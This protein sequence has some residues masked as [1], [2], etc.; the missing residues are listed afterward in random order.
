MDNPE[1]SRTVSPIIDFAAPERALSLFQQLW[2]SAPDAMAIVDQEGRIVLVNALLEQMF[3]Y[4][5]EELL[6]ASI[7]V[8]IPARVREK[9]RKHIDKYR[10]DPRVRAMGIGVELSA[11]RKDGSEFPAEISLAPLKTD[12]GMLIFSSIRDV[13]ERRRAEESRRET[14]AQLLAA[15]RIQEHLLPQAPPTIPGLDIAGASHPA[16]FTGGDYFD[17]LPMTDGSLGLVIA[18]VAGHSFGPALLMATTHA[19]L[20]S[21]AEICTHIE[22]IAARTNTALCRET[23]M[24]RFVTLLL[25]RLDPATRSFTY[26]NAGHPTGYIIDASGAIKATLDSTSVPLGIQADAVFPVSVP[27]LLAP[28]DLVLLLTDGVFE[29][30]SSGGEQFGVERIL[31]FVRANRHKSACELVDS[32]CTAAIAFSDHATLLDDLTIVVVKMQGA[33]D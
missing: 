32:L 30:T 18:D 10:D 7:D 14:R 28:G 11:L 29:T 20:R 4:R 25:G 8:L 6:G 1:R 17:Y 13:T 19:H 22:Q 3:G 15:Q 31:E 9:H 16:E 5:R 24:D 2:S 23:E 12:E 33:S 21:F 26:V 27:I